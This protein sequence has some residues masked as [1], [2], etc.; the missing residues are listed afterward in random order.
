MKRQAA[1]RRR[2]GHGEDGGPSHGH[3]GSG[4]CAYFL[5]AHR[6]ELMIIV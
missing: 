5:V 1:L 6:F 4:R 3:G 2:Q